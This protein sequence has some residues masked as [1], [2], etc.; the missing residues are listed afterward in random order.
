M[1]PRENQQNHKLISGEKINKINKS[2][3]ALIEKRD[4]TVTRQNYNKSGF[5]DLSGLI[6]DWRKGSDVQKTE[7]RYRNRPVGGSLPLPYLSLV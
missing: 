3:A 6:C 2:S 7:A 5:A 4:K 1:K